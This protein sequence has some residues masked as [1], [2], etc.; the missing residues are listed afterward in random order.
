[1][2]GVG[3]VPVAVGLV[4]AGALAAVLFHG[5]I[6]VVIILAA[7]GPGIPLFHILTRVKRDCA[8]QV[9]GSTAMGL[10]ALSVLM[11]GLGY[12]GILDRTVW[13]S[14]ISV[15]FLV[16]LW[17]LAQLVRKRDVSVHP[18]S[19]NGTAL[20][21]F[22]WLLIIPFAV[23]AL[24]GATVPPGI[25]WPGEGGGYDAL[26]YHL[27]AP[28]DYL[29]A[30]RIQYLPHNVYANFPAN[31]EMLYLLAMILHGDP[32]RAGLTCHMLHVLL[33]ALAVAAIWLAGRE[34]S[35]LAGRVAAVMAGTS[36]FLVYLGGLAYVE[37]GLL[38]FSAMTM[39]AV[40]RASCTADG[41]G[42]WSLIAGLFA[43]FACGCKYTGVTSTALPLFVS[44]V[45]ARVLFRRG[46]ARPSPL[47]F[48]MGA[49]LAFAP[50]L[51]KNHFATGNPVFPLGFSVFG[52]REGVWT[53][54]LAEQWHVGHLPSPADR[55]LNR[56]FVRLFQQ[57]IASDFFGWVIG[58]GIAC[59]ILCLFL[60][61]KPDEPTGRHI[62]LLHGGAMIVISLSI[63]MG[64]THLVDRFAY[65]LIAPCALFCGL[66]FHVVRAGHGLIGTTKGVLL[67][68]FSVVYNMSTTVH[69]FSIGKVDADPDAPRLS[70][71]LNYV[72]GRSDAL[73]SASSEISQS[74]LMRLNRELT[75]GRRV[76]VVG[77]ARRFYLERGADYCVVFNRNPFAEA[78]ERHTA[79]ELIGW[80]RERGYQFVYVDWGEMQRLRKTYG[81]WPSI[82]LELFQ[83]LAENGLQPVDQFQLPGRP[84]YGT[85]FEVPSQ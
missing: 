73:I 11:L 64:F 23:F 39:A 5:S 42:R 4:S 14:I 22:L 18:E 74:H 3:A 71:L 81:F 77:D 28:R 49:T 62:I 68:F 60:R 8:W 12:A 19:M 56:R 75:T 59:G 13:I 83:K 66:A 84:P 38:F 35:P 33:G 70:P 63:W 61:R 6:A 31:A 47:L 36:P 65:V 58:I 17:H 2:V 1:M 46:T 52:A 20:F 51:I 45:A 54:A 43:G 55:P 41:T 40:I 29:D 80:L 76:L 57:I 15:A 37:N 85:L 34:F 72:Y 7:L 16:G 21:R 27:G 48:A 32:V 30:G 26:E 79:Q 50:W 9:L 24:L 67:L 25:L 69:L 53:D 82:T 44:L 10:G 78:A